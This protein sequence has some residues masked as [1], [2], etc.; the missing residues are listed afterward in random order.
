MLINQ[1]QQK[2]QTL[3]LSGMARAFEQLFQRPESQNISF[4]DCVGLLADAEVCDRDNRRIARFL[5]SAKLRHGRAT[6]ADID[7]QP[8]RKL[9][10]PL[11]MS[12]SDC[13]WID[14][15]QNLI[16]T[17]ATGTG[18]SW[19]ACAFGLQ[20]CRNGFSVYYTTATQLYEDLAHAQAD[21]SLPKLRR[22]LIKTRL[23]ILDD[24][25]IG[26][27]DTALGPVLLDIIDQQ[28]LQGALLITSQYP[29]SKWY[30]LFND[31]TVADAILDR[32]VHRSH[33]LQLQG[34]SMRKLKA[35]E[36]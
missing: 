3:G 21:G 2:L 34:E 28:T 14:R 8:S 10:Q 20:A 18:K 9:N 32:I 30:D 31:P 29:T 23:L 7:Y 25:G 16:L 33:S 27:V 13:G 6:L 1:T 35:N 12:L 22:L 17:G 5:K 15:R 36:L 19:M 11:I 24:L 4:E 26:G